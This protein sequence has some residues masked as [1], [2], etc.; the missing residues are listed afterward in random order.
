MG[1]PYN[2]LQQIEHLGIS[3]ARYIGTDV[4]KNYFYG[5]DKPVL[6]WSFTGH[7]DIIYFDYPLSKFLLLQSGAFIPLVYDTYNFN[8]EHTG[9]VRG[10]SVDYPLLGI[11]PRGLED[12]MDW[13]EPLVGYSNSGYLDPSLR[14]VGY[15]QA[16]IPAA[17]INYIDYDRPFVGT[18]V[19]SSGNM[20]GIQSDNMGGTMAFVTG[21]FFKGRLKWTAEKSE[22]GTSKAQYFFKTGR[23]LGGIS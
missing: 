7:Q 22:P 10:E 6:R 4:Q 11:A 9:I 12:A 16:T 1:H 17:D 20:L 15:Y 13:D 8:A 14:E 18:M 2:Q 3:N 21:E 23:Y 5:R 19:P